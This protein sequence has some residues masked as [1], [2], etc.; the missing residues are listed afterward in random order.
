[1]QIGTGNAE[2]RRAGSP[3]PA[4]APRQGDGSPVLPRANIVSVQVLDKNGRG[5]VS[6]ILARLQWVLLHKNQYNIRIVNLSFG[7]TALDSYVRDPMAAGPEVAWRNAL[8]VVAAAG[9]TGPQNGNVETPGVDPCVITVGS[10]D[11]HITLNL[12]QSTLGWWSAWGTPTNST[13][14]PDLVA[15]GRQVVA[16]RVPG[17]VLDTLFPAHV[18]KADNG[19]THFRL[20]GTSMSTAIVS[21]AAA[22]VLQRRPDLT[23]EAHFDDEHASVWFGCAS[24]AAWCSG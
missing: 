7:A 4:T 14:K 18:V 16:P 5:Q 11:D 6:S 13:T 20:T 21:G 2:Y 1:M 15:A 9:N 3:R 12:T 22:L 10:T 8:V 24:A 17:S 19:S 23:S